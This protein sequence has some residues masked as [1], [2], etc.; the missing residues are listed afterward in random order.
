MPPIID[1]RFLRPTLASPTFPNR[2]KIKKSD[3]YLQFLLAKDIGPTYKVEYI[4]QLNPM[5][6]VKNPSINL[7]PSNVDMASLKKAII[8]NIDLYDKKY[9][10]L[11]NYDTRK[12]IFHL[13]TDRWMNDALSTV[14]PVTHL[15]KFNRVFRLKTRVPRMILYDP[16]SKIFGD[17][18]IKKFK[19][20]ME[21]RSK[22]GTWFKFLLPTSAARSKLRSKVRNMFDWEYDIQWNLVTATLKSIYIMALLFSVGAMAKKLSDRDVKNKN[23]E[24]SKK[25]EKNLKAFD[26][27]KFEKYVNRKGFV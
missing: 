9:M 21:K 11:K 25:V 8:D 27:K 2:V 15:S 24:F 7:S 19:E 20:W 17:F 4:V 18:V 22:E 5:E 26:L 10:I 1:P 6:A 12:A 16:M 23:I 13:D 14:R 3:V